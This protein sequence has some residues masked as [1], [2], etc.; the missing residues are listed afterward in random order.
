MPCFYGSYGHSSRYVCGMQDYMQV[1]NDSTSL[2]PRLLPLLLL[3]PACNYDCTRLLLSQIQIYTPC[4]DLEQHPRPAKPLRR[5][6]NHLDSAS[7]RAKR[8]SKRAKRSPS[9]PLATRTSCRTPSASGP[10]PT[11]LPS[12]PCGERYQRT[13]QTTG[14]WDGEFPRLF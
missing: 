12:M 5:S 7:T 11:L 4:L 9:P 10:P 13:D 3:L 8:M 6:T 2:V 1:I 14:H